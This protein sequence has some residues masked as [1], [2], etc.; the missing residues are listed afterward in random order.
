MPRSC[1]RRGARRVSAV[2]RPRHRACR[3]G[4]C[5]CKRCA[6]GG[7]K[8]HLAVRPLGDTEPPAH[9][10]EGRCAHAKL[11]R[12]RVQG[13]VKVRPERLPGD[14]RETP[15][16]PDRRLEVVAALSQCRGQRSLVR[17]TLHR[18]GAASRCSHRLS[19]RTWPACRCRGNESLGPR[20]AS[21]NSAGTGCEPSEPAREVA[22]T[23]STHTRL[24]CLLSPPASARTP[25]L[26]SRCAPVR[27]LARVPYRRGWCLSTYF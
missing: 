21:S 8:E 15:I 19:A 6:T 24:P 27:G 22:V 17:H 3:Q 7:G 25:A 11:L 1:H 20:D 10:L 13:Q 16:A 26:S 18:E 5:A 12:H 23:P 2:W 9:L 4:Q 14:R